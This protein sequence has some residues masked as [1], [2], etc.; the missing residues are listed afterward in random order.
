METD[1]LILMADVIAIVADGMPLMCNVADVITTTVIF[2]WC[3]MPLVA[4]GI[5]TDVWCGRCYYHLAD[6]IAIRMEWIGKML[7]PM[8]QM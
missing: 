5:A 4:D 2:S 1:W 3:Y 6:V 7:Q 8:W